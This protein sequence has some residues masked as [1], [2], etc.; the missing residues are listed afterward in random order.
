[1][2]VKDKYDGDPFHLKFNIEDSL[3]DVKIESEKVEEAEKKKNRKK[4]YHNHND[5]SASH[6]YS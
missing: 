5:K 4:S 1:M 2:K 3:S 6:K